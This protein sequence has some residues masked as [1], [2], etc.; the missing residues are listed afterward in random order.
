ML[1]CAM[2]GWLVGLALI[3][4]LVASGAGLWI[5]WDATQTSS[6]DPIAAATNGG[7]VTTTTSGLG[8]VTTTTIPA[9]PACQAGDEAVAAEP[10]AEWATSVIDTAH[11]LPEAFA[12]TD[13]VDV[14]AA[15]F[16]S[17]DQVR[18]FVIEDLAGLRAAAEANGTPVVVISGYRSFS[19]Q[20]DLFQRRVDDVGEA[21]AALRT[22]R[23]GHSEHQLG[24]AIDVL[25]PGVGELTTDFAATPAG[26]WVA[27]HA[28]EFGFVFSYPDGARDRTC[29]EYEPWHLRYVGRDVATE[30]H[31]SGATP[32]EWMLAPRAN[33]A[34]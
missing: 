27:A 15:G 10:D 30:I 4:V 5:T 28:H 12:P 6:A 25:D 1:A 21:E 24:T 3:V 11:R 14:T 23:P 32:R 16:E 33:A 31:D 26:Q 8:P 19:Y 7:L 13:L 22:A 34:G 29:Y 20:Q 2:K 9:A 17:R 18:S